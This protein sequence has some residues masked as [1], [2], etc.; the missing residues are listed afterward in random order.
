[1]GSRACLPIRL[2]RLS[3]DQR[4]RQQQQQEQQLQ[5][6]PAVVKQHPGEREQRGFQSECG[7]RTVT[8]M[9]N[10]GEYNFYTRIRTRLESFEEPFS[11][12]IQQS[13]QFTPHDSPDDDPLLALNP[14]P[15][16]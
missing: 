7:D 8:D 5:C 13:R 9:D 2:L 10:S 11:L 4:Q 14:N 3:V 16:P 1:M 12:E 15:K 6:C